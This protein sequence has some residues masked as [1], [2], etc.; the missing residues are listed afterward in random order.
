MIKVSEA[1]ARLTG[2]GAVMSIKISPDGKLLASFCKVG[3]VKLWDLETFELLATLR[4]REEQDIDEFYV[5]VFSPDQKYIVA[6]GK[7]KDR[8]HWSTNDNDNR[9]LPCSIKVFDTLTGKVAARLDAHSEEVL[10]IKRAYFRGANYYLSCGQD[11][12]IWKWQ[13]SE[14]H[15]QIL[16]R[17]KIADTSNIVFSVSFLPRV[18]NKYF[19]A[20]CDKNLK[21][22]DFESEKVT[23]FA[24]AHRR[25]WSKPS[26][27]S[28]LPTATTRSSSRPTLRFGMS[29]MR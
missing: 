25:S 22:Y 6:G 10:C 17:S 1:R 5:G 26:T 27:P 24:A 29:G 12:C 7:R 20:A 8:R 11:G 13:L 3:H 23:A 9:I 21:L 28:T 14:D 4:D 19:I 15:T 18:G 16:L 2:L